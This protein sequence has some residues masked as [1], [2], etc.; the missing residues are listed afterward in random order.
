MSRVKQHRIK[1]KVAKLGIKCE[2]FVY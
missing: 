2:R 1:A